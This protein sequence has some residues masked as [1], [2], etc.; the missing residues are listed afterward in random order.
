MAVAFPIVVVAVVGHSKV[1]AGPI[2]VAPLGVEHIVVGVA[3]P[4]AAGH[5]AMIAIGADPLVVAHIAVGVAGPTAADPPGVAHTAVGVAG[6]TAADP[7]GV[8]HTAVGVA[9]VAIVDY[10]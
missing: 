6:P 3:G 9:L 1:V 5:I 2:A 8:A 7:L 4:T 10:P